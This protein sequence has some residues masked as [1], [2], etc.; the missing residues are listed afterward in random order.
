[1]IKKNKFGFNQNPSYI[2]SIVWSIIS[3]ILIYFGLKL[4]KKNKLY[5]QQVPFTITKIQRTGTTSSRNNNVNNINNVNNVSTTSYI[6]SGTVDN[7]KDIITVGDYTTKSDN[8]GII[9]IAS[10]NVVKIG[11][12]IFVWIKPNCT[13]SDALYNKSNTA[14]YMLIGL[15]IVFIILSIIIVILKIK[16]KI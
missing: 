16:K 3:I 15:G 9:S 14:G 13:G 1:M 6:L 8:I 10:Q 2:T 4:N 12:K 5:T 11:D 7:C